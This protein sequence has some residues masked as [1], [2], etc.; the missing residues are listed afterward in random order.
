[1][2]SD[3]TII[4]PA[5]RLPDNTEVTKKTGNKEY[6]LKRKFTFYGDDGQT[7]IPEKGSVFLCSEGSVNHY[8]R[9]NI[10]R[11]SHGNT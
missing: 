3:V 7:V 10:S 2:S 11:C 5:W 6:I 1:M 9:N 8:N 4:L